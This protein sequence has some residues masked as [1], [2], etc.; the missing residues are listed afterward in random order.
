V[1]LM[2]NDNN[3][4]TCGHACPATMTC[5]NGACSCPPDKP[6]QCSTNTGLVWCCPQDLTCV[7]CTTPAGTQGA[8][9]C[10]DQR[11]PISTWCP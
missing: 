8:L 4:G 11:T 10:V 3:C 7:S 9:V 5:I 6:K 1:N 2:T